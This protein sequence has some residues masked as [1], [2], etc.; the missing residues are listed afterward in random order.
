M[1]KIEKEKSDL[2]EEQKDILNESGSLKE[3]IST[4]NASLSKISEEYDNISQDIH[5]LT[6]KKEKAETLSYKLRMSLSRSINYLYKHRNTFSIFH[7]LLHAKSFVSFINYTYYVSDMLATTKKKID[8][9]ENIL[10]HIEE[11]NQDLKEKQTE[12]AEK[13]KKLAEENAAA[14]EKL[15]KIWQRYKRNEKDIKKLVEEMKRREIAAM[16]RDMKIVIANP[17]NSFDPD[18]G[19]TYSTGEDYYYT[20]PYECSEED[21]YLLACLIQSEAGNQ[22]YAGKVAV[23]SVVMNRVY[24]SRFPGTIP[25]VIYQKGQFYPYGSGR[26]AVIL[27]EG[28]REDCMIAA[29]DVLAGKRNVDKFFYRTASCAAET[30]ITG[31]QIGDHVF[32][33]L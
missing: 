27:A 26:L 21:A 22:T 23:G 24:D 8:E 15:K 12:L 6:E 16:E 20:D 10:A 5:I 3:S 25:S 33:D 1:N 32:H 19:N 4:I 13:G 17:D 28:C 29:R 31:I 30:G 14:Q 7:A 9:Y 18:S 2:E 11:V